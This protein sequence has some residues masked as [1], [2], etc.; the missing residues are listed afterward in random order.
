MTKR[1]LIF[2]F[3]L[4]TIIM[5]SSIFGQQV[6]DKVLAIIEDEIILQSELTQFSVNYALQMNINPKLNPE[7]FEALQ[8][9]VLQNMITQKILLAKAI[10]DTIEVNEREVDRVLNEQ[11]NRMVEQ[12]GSV[13]KVEE[14][15]G[16]TISKIKRDFRKEV[17]DNL[18]VEQLKQMK[19]AKIQIS[20]REVEEFYHSKRDSLPDFKETVDISHILL[21]IK[22][23]KDAEEETRKKMEQILSRIKAGEDFGELATRYSEDPGSKNRRGELGFFKRGEFV[24]EFEQAAFALKPGEISD[25][26]RSEH[27]FHI[28]QMIERRG[29]KINVR[30]ILLRLITTREDEVETERRIYEIRRMLD[31]PGADFAELAKKYSDDATS[32]DQGGH[33][34]QFTVED[35]QE[36]EFKRAIAFLEPGEISKPFK[37]RFGWHIIK[38]NSREE[39]RELSI[40]KDW[41]YIE[42]W[43]LNMKQQKEFQKWVDELKKE[44]FVDIKQ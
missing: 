14:Y 34:G 5:S 21:Q 16:T 28:I 35:L 7:K 9:E 19:L 12:L 26:V 22:P 3:V 11:I 42:Q 40:D 4:T 32:K 31:E 24:P 2:L 13:E 39:A 38:L 18:K 25:I 44:T 27:G 29:E 37:T 10:E 36:P 20:R 15:M 30:H 1:I 17:E 33:L 23:G 43:A 6:L 8:N 41:E